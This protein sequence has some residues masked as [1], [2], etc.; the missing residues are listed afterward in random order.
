VNSLTAAASDWDYLVV[1]AAGCGLELG[2]YPAEVAGK[3]RDALVLLAGLSLPA[4]REMPLKIVLHDPCHARQGQR[5]V[6]APRRLLQRIPGL[7]V[8]EPDE[9]EVCCGSGGV[10]SLY[11]PEISAAMGRRK[12]RMLAAPGAHLVVTSNPGCLGQIAEGLALEVPELPILPLTDLL[13]FAHLGPR[14]S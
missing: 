3:V 10:Y 11:H 12:A 2:D 8:V 13:W 9:P 7:I 1:E 6:E 5:I 14:T 4:P